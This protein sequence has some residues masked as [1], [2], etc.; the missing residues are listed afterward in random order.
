MA[1]KIQYIIEFI[2]HFHVVII[3]EMFDTFTHR[4]IFNEKKTRKFP[5]NL[6]SYPI[7]FPVLPLQTVLIARTEE[8]CPILK[9]PCPRAAPTYH[10]FTCTQYTFHA[11]ISLEFNKI[12]CVSLFHCQYYKT[13]YHRRLFCKDTTSLS[14]VLFVHD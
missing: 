4:K 11:Q 12:F 14:L 10:C 1:T 5:L 9:Y 13:N 7:F 2:Y 8:F 3:Q 6:P